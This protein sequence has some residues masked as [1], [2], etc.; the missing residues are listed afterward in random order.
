MRKLTSSSSPWVKKIKTDK[1]WLCKYI[2]KLKRI[3]KQREAKMNEMN[4]HAIS[5]LQRNF[6]SYGLPKL[7]IRCFVRIY[8][9]GLEAQPGKPTNS[10]KDHRKAKN[11][12]FSRYGERWVE[13]LK[14]SS[15]TSKFFC[16]T[17]LI[18]FIMKEA[19][20][21]MKGSVNEDDL[22]IVHDQA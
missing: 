6:W 11:M 13:K 15:S 21:L 9:H 5:D 16:I 4:I 22:F 14:S 19:E 17:D 12:Y 1:I 8:E 3:G 10:I 2:G 18:W 20:K 7:P